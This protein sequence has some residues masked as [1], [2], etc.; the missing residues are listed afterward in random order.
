M[1]EQENK[2]NYYDH[3]EIDEENEWKTYRGF[4]YHLNFPDD[5]ILNEIEHTGRACWNCVGTCIED[6]IPG[7][8]MW[9]GIVIGYCANCAEVY[10]FKRGPGFIE[11]G[12]EN[13][14]LDVPS[15]FDTYLKN[16]VL[17]DDDG[18]DALIFP[19]ENYITCKNELCNKYMMLTQ[20]HKCPECHYKYCKNGCCELALIGCVECS[21]CFSDYTCKEC[22]IEIDRN[23]NMCPQCLKKCCKNCRDTELVHSSE[24]CADCYE[25]DDNDDINDYHDSDREYDEDNFPYEHD[26]HDDESD[27]DYSKVIHGQYVELEN[28]DTVPISELKFGDKVKKNFNCFS[29]VTPTKTY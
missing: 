17:L 9:D 20:Y 3:I 10:E 24:F 14:I 13:T 4:K 18:N 6:P 29:G 2:M 7:Y 27:V 21:T 19:E 8:A 5:W 23:N 16:V 22:N 25:P 11:C 12:L 1:T 28:G 26:E 15:A